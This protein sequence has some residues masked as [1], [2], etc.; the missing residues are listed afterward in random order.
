MKQVAHLVMWTRPWCLHL[1]ES[2]PFY[3]HKRYLL[4]CVHLSTHCT[5]IDLISFASF[6][7][8]V[9]YGRF[10]GVLLLLI[11]TKSIISML[12]SIEGA[13]T[14]HTCSLLLLG[15]VG[16]SMAPV[17]WSCHPYLPTWACLWTPMN[18]W[19]RWRL[20]ALDASTCKI[21]M[22]FTRCFLKSS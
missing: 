9:P 8:F 1:Q 21:L 7:L 18:N 20:H 3:N 6:A 10:V 11:A 19:W 16:L 13:W 15:R 12:F 14:S 5:F 17:S 4:G 2:L 22:P